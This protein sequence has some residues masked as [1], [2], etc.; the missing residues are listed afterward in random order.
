MEEKTNKKLEEI[1]KFLK[2]NQE[3]AGEGKSSGFE[4]GNT[5][6]KTKKTQMEGMLESEN[7]DKQTRATDASITNRMQEIEESLALK[8]L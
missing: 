3:K 8:I 6:N 5:G 4:N 1:N 2:E 7:L